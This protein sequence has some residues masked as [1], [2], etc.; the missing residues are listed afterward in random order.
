M[1]YIFPF[2]PK[3]KDN[4]DNIKAGIKKIETR[5]GGPKYENIV[6]GDSVSFECGGD[7]FERT[8]TKVTKFNDVDDMLKVYKPKEINTAMNTAEDLKA[9]YRSFPG[10]TERLEK[11]GIIAFEI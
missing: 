6:V 8:I 3:D 2:D 7:S 10:Y 11:F 9:L 4:F 1:K 5:A